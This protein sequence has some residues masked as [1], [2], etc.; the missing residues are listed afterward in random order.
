MGRGLS[1]LQRRILLLTLRER[2]VLCK[3]LLF[4]WG[5]QPGAVVDKGT[6]GAAHSALSRTLTRL[7]WRGLIEIWQN[8]LTH[9]GT[10][11]TLTKMGRGLAQAI[12]AKD[13]KEQV[14]G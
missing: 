6:Y 8:K 11:V 7:W 10:G 9:Y 4:L 5:V 3:D 14:N 2:F 13:Q 12:F 1:Q